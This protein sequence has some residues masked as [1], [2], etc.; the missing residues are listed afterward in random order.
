MVLQT[1]TNRVSTVGSVEGAMK[2]KMS[3][4]ALTVSK[5]KWTWMNQR[6][7]AMTRVIAEDY[8]V[9]ISLIGELV[10]VMVEDGRIIEAEAEEAI[11]GVR[12]DVDTDK[13]LH[14][15]PGTHHSSPENFQERHIV[16]FFDPSYTSSR[17]KDCIHAVPNLA[18]RQLA[19]RIEP[20][21]ERLNAS[22][23]AL[24]TFHNALERGL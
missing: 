13:H 16:Y 18:C 15:V 10:V 14:D 3:W 11:A 1:D 6:K 2:E 19:L 7:T 22:A 17:R 23:L 20:M 24:P 21:Q 9:M 5:S 8:I 4:T 12:E